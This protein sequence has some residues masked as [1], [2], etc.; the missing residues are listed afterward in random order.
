MLSMLGMDYKRHTIDLMNGTHQTS[1]LV[2]LNSFG[3]VPVLQE[4]A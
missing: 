2:A 4:G 1:A 3:Q